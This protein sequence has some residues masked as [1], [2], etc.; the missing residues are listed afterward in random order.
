MGSRDENIEDFDAWMERMTD[1]EFRQYVHR[2]QLNRTDI[3]KELGFA[4]SALTQ[5]PAIKQKLKD[6]E[7]KLREKGVLPPLADKVE[8][9]SPKKNPDEDRVRRLEAENAM[10]RAELD[11]HKKFIKRYRLFEKFMS[12]TVRM[13]R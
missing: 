3:A 7:E 11:Q 8:D 9:A 5:N 1:D 4:K 10:L 12:E 2:G 6:L 13:P